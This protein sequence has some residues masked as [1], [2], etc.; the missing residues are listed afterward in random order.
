MARTL[1]Q[2][3]PGDIARVSDV[4]GDAALTQRILEMGIL[5]GNDVQLVRVAPLGDPMEFA[6]LGY[7]ISLRKSEAACVQCAEPGAA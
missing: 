7:R 1:A 3:K 2:L 6:V 5:P 4:T